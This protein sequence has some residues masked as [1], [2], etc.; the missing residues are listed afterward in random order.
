MYRNL[1][2]IQVAHVNYN[3]RD[4]S[5]E[6]QELVFHFCNKYKI[7]VHVKTISKSDIPATGFEAWA[8]DIR[9][10]FFNKIMK[11]EG[12]SKLATA[13]NKN[14]QAETVIMR[15]MRGTGLK[16]LRGIHRESDSIIRPI[17]DMNKTEVYTYCKE[18][19]VPYR[20]DSTNSDTIYLRN[21]IRHT[22]I[23][24][25]DIDAL[26]RIADIS[27]KIYPKVLKLSL[28]RLAPYVKVS[29]NLIEIDRH[30]TLDE[31]AFYGLSKY[32][33]NWFSLS[34]EIY[35]QIKSDMGCDRRFYI[36]AK[37]ICDKRS[38][39]RI[40]IFFEQ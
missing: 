24:H 26:S 6:D 1:P 39:K 29:A 16:G 15:I 22:M 40:R 14:D 31:L 2:G 17:L 30:A 36:N 19:S 4:D 7:P 34:S 18:H 32:F 12:I 8:R 10:D 37:V 28:D 13:H 35:Q 11:S 20:E 21:K 3:F 25:V 9:Y 5:I 23:P 38:P 27:Q 33:E